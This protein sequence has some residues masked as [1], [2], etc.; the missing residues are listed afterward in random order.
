M[1]YYHWQRTK[2]T[3]QKDIYSYYVPFIFFSKLHDDQKGMLQKIT[4][5]VYK[6]SVK[7]FFQH[8]YF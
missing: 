4:I 6:Y 7:Y 5:V 1:K 3:T 2:K 8:I